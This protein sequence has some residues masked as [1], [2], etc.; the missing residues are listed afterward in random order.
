M[1][2][3]EGVGQKKKNKSGNAF[4]IMQYM[5]ASL[6]VKQSRLLEILIE[7][8]DNI[9]KFKLG[10]GDILESTDGTTIKSRIIKRSTISTTQFLF[11][12][13]WSGSKLGTKHFGALQ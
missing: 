13:S 2:S 11:G 5:L 4:Q 8:I 1:R 3:R 9:S 7:F 10:D 6:L 12:A